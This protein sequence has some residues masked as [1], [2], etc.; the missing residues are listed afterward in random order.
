VKPPSQR[1]A[2]YTRK[3]TE[4]GLD[5]E[6]NSIDAQQE[7][8]RA[9]ITSQKSLGWL[10]IPE[11]YDDGGFSG[12]NMERPGL[13][14]LMDDIKAKR[15]NIVVVYKVDRLTR[16]L[17]DFTKLLDVFDQYNVTFISITQSFNTTT[18]MDRLTLNIL[19]SFAQFER[20]VTTERIRDKVAASK[21]KGIWMG[22]TTPTGYDV[23]NRMLIPNTEAGFVRMVFGRYLELGNICELVRDFKK[24]DIKSPI[25]TRVDGKQVGDR[26]FTSGALRHML[27]NPVYIGKIRHKT[28]LY[29]GL[30]EPIIPVDLW[31]R[32]QE[33]VKSR[34]EL[35][36]HE[37]ILLANPNSLTRKLFDLEGNRYSIINSKGNGCKYQYYLSEKLAREGY[38]DPRKYISRIPVLEIEGHVQKSLQEYLKDPG[39]L[40]EILQLDQEKN[41]DILQKIANNREKLKH[42][43]RAINKV[44]VETY[45]VQIE[46]Q[47]FKLGQYIDEILQT[48]ISEMVVNTVFKMTVPFRSVSS[49]RGTILIPADKEADKPKDIFDLPH[50]VLKNIVCGVVW[51]EK[52]FKGKSISQIAAE[53]G[54]AWVTVEK[55][56]QR[57]FERI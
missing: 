11:N 52:H 42:T 27:M 29:N 41:P 18:S 4:E 9:Y 2:V 55:R 1:C 31:E 13:K 45:R 21:Q 5:Q 40:N 6:F 12:G 44:I 17:V 33:I 32:V 15:V 23:K 16:A 20:E 50:D 47:V 57:S 49:T 10:N 24:R 43:N 51:R 39:K 28:K 34:S 54:A 46:L 3:S 37:K 8:C 7:A 22:G 48:E 30:H 38:N 19:L 14:K 56:I 25:R 36:R 53:D 35:S 26:E